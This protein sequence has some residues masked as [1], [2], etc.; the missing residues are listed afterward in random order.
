MYIQQT[1]GIVFPFQ[2]LPQNIQ[3]VFRHRI[4]HSII[5]IVA[6]LQTNNTLNNDNHERRKTIETKTKKNTLSTVCVICKFCDEVHTAF[7]FRVIHP[8][9]EIHNSLH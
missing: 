2:N 4:M 5:H 6:P 1:N 7:F 8:N 3:L 9:G